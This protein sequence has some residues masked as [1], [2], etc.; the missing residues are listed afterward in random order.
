M[1]QVFMLGASSVYGVGAEHAGWGDLIKQY[2]HSKMFSEGGIGE[3]YEIYNFA[4]S[5][6]TID[7]I[8]DT[9]PT[10]LTNYGKGEKVITI[11]S[12]GG[13]NSRAKDE[14]TNFASTPASYTTELTQLIEL[15]KASS[16]KVIFV[17]TAYVDETKT[18]PITT[19]HDNKY[20]FTNARRKQFEE[21]TKE[22]CEQNGIDFASIVVSEEEWI[23]NYTFKDGLHPNQAGHQLL[24][25]A[26]EPYL[27]ELEPK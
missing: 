2:F 3:K 8:L 4:K 7:F 26:I 24:F 19:S 16:E 11:V 18:N 27:L 5:G 20:Y 1:K 21:I 22:L 12:V 25:D 9:F 15:L 14:P 23:K 13:N 17:S 10:H 6:A